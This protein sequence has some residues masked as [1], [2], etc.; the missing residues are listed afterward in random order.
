LISS[1]TSAASAC[2]QCLCAVSI[3]LPSVVRSVG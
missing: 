2:V 3:C 1:A